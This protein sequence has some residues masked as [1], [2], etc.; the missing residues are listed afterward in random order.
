MSTESPRLSGFV[1]NMLAVL[2][3]YTDAILKET[4]PKPVDGIMSHIETGTW[5][6]FGMNYG[7]RTMGPFPYPPLFREPVFRGFLKRSVANKWKFQ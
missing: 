6:P 2:P 4:R 3:D 7:P 1:E 5:G